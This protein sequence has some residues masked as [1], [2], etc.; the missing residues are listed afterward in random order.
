MVLYSLSICNVTIPFFLMK[1][2]FSGELMAGGKKAIQIQGR[3]GEESQ[4]F[5]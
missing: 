4:D 2:N 3:E 1:S 5:L